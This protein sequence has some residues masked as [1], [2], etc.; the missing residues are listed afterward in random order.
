MLSAGIPTTDTSATKW[1]SKA[2]A[3]RHNELKS[4]TT[5]TVSGLRAKIKTTSNLEKRDR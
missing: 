4:W 5:G 1:A 3:F 2:I